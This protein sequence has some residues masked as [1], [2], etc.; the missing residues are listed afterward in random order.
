M[1]K[2]Q[3]FKN[4][5]SS[6]LWKLTKGFQQ[7]KVVYAKLK[8]TNQ[9]NQP[10]NKK[11]LIWLRTVGFW[12]FYL[13]IFPSPPPRLYSSIENQL[14]IDKGKTISLVDS[15]GVAGGK[16]DWKDGTP[17]HFIHREPSLHDLCGGSLQGCLYLT[18]SC[19]FRKF[20]CFQCWKLNLG[21]CIC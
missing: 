11:G 21:L 8:P 19:E 6:E 20:V 18:W 13:A 5:H 7:P 12:Y 1:R 17:P 15:A 16:E 3:A 10:Q 14:P 2:W 4:Q 9:T